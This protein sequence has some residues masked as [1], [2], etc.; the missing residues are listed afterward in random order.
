MINTEIEYLSNSMNSACNSNNIRGNHHL[1]FGGL[2]P[3]PGLS[4]LLLLPP[5]IALFLV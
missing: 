4:D 2:M 3:I 1:G 5:T